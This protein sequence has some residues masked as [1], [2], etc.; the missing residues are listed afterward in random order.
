MAAGIKSSEFTLTLSE[1]ERSHLLNFLEQA[2]RAKGIE[3]H[4][5]DALS[6]KEIFQHQEDLLRSLI[7][8]LRRV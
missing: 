5:T 1:E 4:R 8:K 6:A 7:A 2:L 3:V